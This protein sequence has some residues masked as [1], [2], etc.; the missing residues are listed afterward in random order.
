MTA[1]V[2]KLTPEVKACPRC[3][4]LRPISD[5]RTHYPSNGT[6]YG[7]CKSCR[8]EKKNQWEKD[9][10]EKTKAKRA[11]EAEKA[12]LARAEKRAKAGKPPIEKRVTDAGRLCSCCKGRFPDD[13]FVTDNRVLS[14]KSTHCKKCQAEK[15][16][17]LKSRNGRNY[18]DLARGYERKG[19]YGIT[20]E[21][22]FD[23]VK[24]QKGVCAICEDILHTGARG[25]CVDHDHRTG[26]IRGILCVKCNAGLGQFR[27]NIQFLRAAEDYLL[28]SKRRQ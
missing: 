27:D 22:F 20:P 24:K 15:R 11:D 25:A 19:R 28:S 26:F 13:A 16:A 5:F 8:K 14:G 7:I 17:K 12:R 2:I 1:S 21:Q 9:N 18:R 10:P 3:E 6:R 4:M 23:M